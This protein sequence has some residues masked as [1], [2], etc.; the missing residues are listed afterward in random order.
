MGLL[1]NAVNGCEAPTCFLFDAHRH[2]IVTCNNWQ[3]WRLSDICCQLSQPT[4]SP[5]DPLLHLAPPLTAKHSLATLH[6]SHRTAPPHTDCTLLPMQRLV[7]AL[8]LLSAELEAE[9]ATLDLSGLHLL[10]CSKTSLDS[11]GTLCL[12]SDDSAEDWADFLGGVDAGYARDKRAAAAALRQLEAG[13]AA[14]LGVRMLFTAAHYIMTHEY[15]CGVV[16]GRSLLDCFSFASCTLAGFAGVC[17]AVGIPFL[18]SCRPAAAVTDV[19]FYHC[20]QV[21]P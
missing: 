11:L 10:I 18:L 20:R 21:V 13:V 1:R 5:A 4:P 16:Q 19:A 17:R 15:R 8:N 9:G 6:L 12:A 2:P 3:L 14:A 7:D